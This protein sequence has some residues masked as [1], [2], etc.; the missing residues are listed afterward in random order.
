MDEDRATHWQGVYQSKNP[1][2]VSWHT[3]HLK[4][5]LALLK[6]AG[7]NPDSRVI[8]IGAGASTLLDDLLDLG[9]RHVSALDISAASLEVTRQRLGSR[10]ALV[11]WL[12][13]DV[14]RAHLPPDSYDL[15]HDRAALH[16]LVNP[17]ESAAYVAAASRAIISGGCA[18]IGGF[19][20]DGPERC[21]QLPVVR[22]DPGD[23][24]ELF[25][26]GFLLVE[27]QRELHSTPWGASQSFAYAL[28]RKISYP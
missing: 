27:S 20:A 1:H 26:S 15:W 28:L 14:S 23:I 12:V 22:R 11:N 25:G 13:T 10:A 18:V 5:S 6:Q 3:P 19:A 7:L 16:F 21:S 2:E 17:V 24:A 9:V 4:V 8:D